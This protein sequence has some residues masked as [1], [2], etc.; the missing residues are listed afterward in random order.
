[1]TQ[2]TKRLKDTVLSEEGVRIRD[3][4]DWTDISF[5]TESKQC[6]QQ[7]WI[8]SFYDLFMSFNLLIDP[9]VGKLMWFRIVSSQRSSFLFFG[10]VCGQCGVH[11]SIQSLVLV[12]K[13]V[14]HS[15]LTGP[16][17]RSH[18][19]KYFVCRHIQLLRFDWAL[20]EGNYIS[21]RGQVIYKPWWFCF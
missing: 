18:W 5:M 2:Q 17:W 10:L 11:I 15:C 20:L 4:S 21:C 3:S 8:H 13:C 6:W 7:C 9:H 16:K 14:S 19:P 12:L 1:M